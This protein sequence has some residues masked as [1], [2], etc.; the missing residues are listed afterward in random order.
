MITFPNAKINIGLN[1]VSRRP[2]G[3]H[4]LETIFYPVKLCD[5]LEMVESEKTGLSV[6]GIEINASANDN[7]V[8]KAYHLLK[9]DFD[10]PPVQF[11]LHK[12]IPF[13]AGL[14]GGSSDAAFALKMLN[15]H[16]ELGLSFTALKKYAS[17]IG[18]DCSFFIS[19][20]PAF[21]SE[22]GDKLVPVELNLSPYHVVI[23]K[24]GQSVNT[25]EAYRNVVPSEPDF[26]LR[27]LSKLPVEEWEKMVK[28]DFE[29][30]IFKKVPEIGQ[31]KK[32]LYESG[33]AYAS[34]TGSGSAVYGIFRH[35]PTD[36]DKFIP[37]GIFIY[38]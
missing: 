3:Y 37:D 6:S 4:N 23:L 27:Q 8:L 7:L 13:G 26:D 11:H 25:S 15:E 20:Q 24:P 12:V 18:A 1:I 5:A 2:D 19:N 29:K 22:K 21:A 17:R 32:L 36:I 10:L 31:L 35:S 9:N 38:R 28:N 34:M 30:S 16:F 14:G 33:A